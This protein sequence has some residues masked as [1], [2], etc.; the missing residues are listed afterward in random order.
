[1]DASSPFLFFNTLHDLIV[2]RE[3]VHEITPTRLIETVESIGFQAKLLS[4]KRLYVYP[5]YT[6]IAEKA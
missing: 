2:S 4:Q 1:M 3:L 5:H 6:V